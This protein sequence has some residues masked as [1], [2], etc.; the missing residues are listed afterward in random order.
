MKDLKSWSSM[1]HLFS[2]VKP[3]DISY[4]K[5]MINFLKHHWG[6]IALLTIVAIIIFTNTKPNHFILGND[7]F[8]P[9]LNPQLTLQRIINNPAWRTHRALGLPS[10]S[11]QADLF[12]TLTYSLLSPI[13]PLWLISQGYLFFTLIIATYSIG[14]LTKNLI[15]KSK[16]SITIFVA[17]IFYLANLLT[18]WIYFYPVHLFVATYAFLPFLL[19]R[20]SEYAIK[21]TK[22]NK[23]FLLLST[24][25]LS[26][27]ALTATMFITSTILILIFSLIFKLKN[28]LNL[29]TTLIAFVIIFSPHLFWILPFSSYVKTNSPDLQNSYINREITTS[30]IENESRFN[31]L[32]N[33]LRFYSS[34]LDTKEDGV[35]YTYSNRD[36]F[37]TNYTATLIGL[38]PFILASL[39]T[40]HLLLSKKQ[41][42]LILSL[43]AF[44]GIFM[45]TG[46]NPPLGNFFSWLQINIP[47]FSQVFR[48]QS[49][50]LWPLLLLP[51]TIL[52]TYLFY[53]L[54]RKSKLSVL[55]TLPLLIS[56]L[57]YI[58]P[59]F[60][61]NL[62]RNEVFT[63]IPPEYSALATYLKSNHPQDRLY[64]SPQ[65]NTRYFRKY[66]WGFWGSVFLNYLLENPIIE[67]A[68]I[69]G[70]DE[71][72]QAY[73]IIVASYYSSNPKTFNQALDYYHTPLILSDQSVTNQGLS[74]SFSYPYDWQYHSKMTDQNPGITKIWQQ[75]N[76]TLYQRTTPSSNPASPISP[77]HHFDNLSLLNLAAQNSNPTYTHPSGT[78]YPL[79][80]AANTIDQT[81][82]HLQLNT[83]FTGK[84]TTYTYSIPQDTLASAPTLITTTQN[85]AT[86]TP[87]LPTLFVNQSPTIS[88]PQTLISLPQ[89]TAF[90]SLAQ[91]VL[92]TN[93]TQTVST[94]YSSLPSSIKV[95]T[96]QST[97]TNLIPFLKD[98]QTTICTKPHTPL[99]PITGSDNQVEFSATSK[100]CASF[101]YGITKNTIATISLT[102]SAN[103]PTPLSLCV[104]SQAKDRCL[105]QQQTIYLNQ[106]PQTANLTINNVIDSQDRLTFFLVTEPTS[107]TNISLTNFSLSQH[108]TNTSIPLNLTLLE[109]IDAQITLN[110]QDTL[111]TLIPIIT[112]PKV[113]SHNSPFTNLLLRPFHG[114]CTT[115]TTSDAFPT[116]SFSHN[117]TFTSLDCIDG[118]FSYFETTDT[119]NPSLALIFVQSTNTQGIPLE[120]SLRD[121]QNNRKHFVDLLNS[122][123]SS[124]IF[125]F[126]LL[127][128]AQT[129]FVAEI[130]SKGIGSKPS[131]NTLNEFIIQPIPSSWLNLALIPQNLSP[132]SLSSTTPTHP[133]DTGTFTASLNQ[134]GIYT[135][136]TATHENW[137]ATLSKSS[138]KNLFSLY[139][140]TY[141]SDS[142]L[143]PTII[144]GWQQGW[145][146]TNEHSDKTLT[147]IFTPN[148]LAYLG[149]FLG[150][151][152]T[153][154]AILAPKSPPPSA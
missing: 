35:N 90:L 59:F 124:S 108:Q 119:P 39:A 97:S 94:L 22:T 104:H 41:P 132:L 137:K 17:G 109:P 81:Q 63:Q 19:W 73:N 95:W 29:K 110:P 42:I 98:K 61:G 3:I 32:P 65:S 136:P 21:P 114:E 11:E 2:G 126:T 9:E 70:S 144:N 47:F 34:W 142:S 147:A 43:T 122:N 107:T 60:T 135:L 82:N 28:K 102:A 54:A 120:V 30:T 57:Y 153:A 18:A 25:L 139:S 143:Q 56:Q 118:I 1:P 131:I 101:D 112:S 78:I 105:N 149:F 13:L 129:D 62:I 128:Q 127:P 72:Q 46:T 69:I 100:T 24:L 123:Q 151:T 145:I 75:G 91:N 130:A 10:D 103:Q 115:R 16:S 117:L 53:K 55:L 23:V 79:A 146:T 51:T 154:L 49:S 83:T 33:T 77:Q 87:A 99:G 74:D 12:R 44:I 6:Q 85:Q 148:V 92:L 93:N 45:I 125:S 14:K 58:Y 116:I 67:K 111:S 150:I 138:T 71:N 133:Q 26:T 96:N 68:L 64:I 152:F 52:A 8:S 86:V 141:F 5:I 121:P 88:L 7:N 15:T 140:N 37:T 20:F 48:W 113:I 106:T 40:I 66:S 4:N 36:W 80:L 31:T 27:S 134:P 89:N 76:L 38:I 50:K 84:A